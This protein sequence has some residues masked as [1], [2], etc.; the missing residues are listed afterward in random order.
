MSPKQ[1]LD[2][3]LEQIKRSETEIHSLNSRAF[4]VGCFG[5]LL[6]AG[7]PIGLGV[8]VYN[9]R[10]VPGKHEF[11]QIAIVAVFAAA[12]SY[13]M[14][15]PLRARAG[16]THDVGSARYG[17]EIARPVI[18]LLR[19][20][21]NYDPKGAL[22]MTSLKASRLFNTDLCDPQPGVGFIPIISGHQIRGV[23][24][25]LPFVMH[26]VTITGHGGEFQRL[27][28]GFFQRF[29]LP[30][31]VGGRLRVRS[32]AGD[33]ERR[34]GS[35]GL[36]VVD[37][38]VVRL[39][40]VYEVEATGNLATRL[41]TREMA[42]LLNSQAETEFTCHL[43]IDG[44]SAWIAIDRRRPWFE[45]RY[46]SLIAAAGVEELRATFDFTDAMA[47]A[48]QTAWVDQT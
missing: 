44:K 1:N 18:A 29:E 28:T 43:S 14:S 8:L 11:W 21:F 46:N 4:G 15:R 33:P 31:D 13:F 3:F 35:A 24:A 5:V 40:P 22:T 6:G 2:D 37:P 16:R 12:L 27:L 20:D 34:P 19:P 41:V 7:V 39:V 9:W 47:K 42:T 32:T 48:I 45:A 25:G 23:V 30:F 17:E 36:N 38:K 10:E 26:E